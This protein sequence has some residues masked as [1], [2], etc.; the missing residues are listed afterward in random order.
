MGTSTEVEVRKAVPDFGFVAA[1][2]LVLVLEPEPE[3]EL[4]PV[5]VLVP[6]PE[7]EPALVAA[8]AQQGQTHMGDVVTNTSLANQ[9]LQHQPYQ[10]LLQPL[11]QRPTQPSHDDDYAQQQR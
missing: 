7:L 10:K 1:P 5:L 2:A 4:V 8:V 3:P 6:G 11:Q 9:T